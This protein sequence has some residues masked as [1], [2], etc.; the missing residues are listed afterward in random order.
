MKNE[1]HLNGSAVMHEP[2]PPGAA[3]TLAGQGV[4]DGAAIGPAM[5]VRYKPLVTEARAI[6]AAEVPTEQQRLTD[7]LAAS[8]REL[9][10]LASQVERSVGSAEAGIFTAQALMLADPSLAEDAAHRIDAERIDAASALAAAGAAQADLLRGLG[11]PLFSGRAADVEDAVGRAIRILR[12][13]NA[14]GL[15]DAI[16]EF[17]Q[18][19]ILVARDLAPSQTVELREAAI[20]GICLA[21]GG[22]TSHAAILA[23]AM[24]IPAVVGVGEDAIEQIV[25]GDRLALDATTGRV[26]LRPDAATIQAVQSAIAA[27]RDRESTARSEAL[28][29]R[30]LP[31]MTRDGWRVTIA[32]NIASVAESLAAGR[33]WGAESIGLLR[34]EF[35]FAGRQTMPDEDEQA[36]IYAHL[37]AAFAD[38]A[39]PTKHVVARTLDAG[40]DKPLPALGDTLVR[41]D[42]PALGLRGL[43]VHLRHP[44]WLRTQ[45]RAL[46]RAAAATRTPLHIM[47]PMVATI[48]ELRAARAIVSQALDEVR[49]TDA[50]LTDVPLG[51]MVETPAACLTSPVLAREAEFFSIGTN[52]LTQY[53]MACDRLNA[54]V[55]NL[56]DPCQPA[57]LRAID[58][59]VRAGQIAGRS[60]AV[61]GEMAG[62]P[63]LALLLAGLGVTELSMNA[64]QI[65]TVKAALARW[66]ILDLR[67]W[68]DRVLQLD[69]LDEV[70]AAIAA[71]PGEG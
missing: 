45:A 34:T 63:Q 31:G 48:E 60:V 62:D 57:V 29:W 70:R 49:A 32:A 67:R 36:E 56:Y 11:D 64:A 30:D 68:A 53:V 15:A 66:T 22:P 13:G 26:F 46:G 9:E 58:Q 3:I 6:A 28:R 17:D 54:Q 39:H 20:A 1:H 61:C 16:A 59:I 8:A 23:R 35:L 5:I 50:R 65:P 19:P 10:D 4:S 51:I 40:A 71:G 41:E 2:S 43:R 69:T 42:N 24:R 27:V 7:A 18:P 14:P 25:S 47:F 38:R 37:F 21:L 33:D 44:D 52:D 55:A 12:A